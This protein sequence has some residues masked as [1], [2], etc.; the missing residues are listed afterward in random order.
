MGAFAATM[1]HQIRI[2]MTRPMNLAS[3]IVSPLL[4]MTLLTAPRLERVTP[5]ETTAVFTGSLLA[6]LW[7][8][9]MWSGAGILR[10]ERWAGTLAPSFTA[11]PS[12]LVILLGKTLGGV[13]YD[14]A[15]IVTAQVIFCAAFGLPLR[16]QD[17][18][19]FAVGVAA[20][21]A[22]GVA[23]SLMIG[24]LL[25]LSRYAFQLTTALGMPVLLLGGTIIPP[26]LLPGWISWLP[27]AI[28]LS[29]LQRFLVSTAHDTAW[30]YLGIAV[31]LS[32]LYAV[33]GVRAV[34]VMLDRARREGSLDLA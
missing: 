6:S 4:F 1:R 32:G 13:V 8:T 11:R 34:G 24:A 3:G 12:P 25:M 22:C 16:V 2:V 18:L 5:E 17:P 19:A 10:R 9:S 20:V 15:L 26:S 30:L 21:V 7:A 27:N 23:S 31:G 29:W 28:N 14:T 33:V